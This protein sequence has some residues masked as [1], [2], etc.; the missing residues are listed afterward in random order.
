MRRLRVTS[1]VKVGEDVGSPEAVD[2]LLR[3]AHEEHRKA[4]P[5]IDAIEDGVLHRIGILEFV[6]ERGAVTRSQRSHELFPAF[7]GQRIPKIENQIV[8]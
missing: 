3:I 4:R 1:R 5:A 7:T 6:D 8:V 2:R